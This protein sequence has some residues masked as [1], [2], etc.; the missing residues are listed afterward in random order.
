MTFALTN[1][2]TTTYHKDYSS[3]VDFNLWQNESGMTVLVEDGTI[4]YS[5]QDYT[6]AGSDPWWWEQASS[7]EVTIYANNKPIA[8][9]EYSYGYRLAITEDMIE[10]GVTVIKCSK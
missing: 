2:L 8:T 1:P 9:G 7:G 10:D 4:L 5:S 6:V 3:E